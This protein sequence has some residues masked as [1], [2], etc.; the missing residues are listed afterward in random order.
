MPIEWRP[1]ARQ[2]HLHNEWVSY[3]MA[4]PDTAAWRTSTSVQLATCW[5]L[6][7]L[8]RLT[9][10]YPDILF[11]SCASGGGRFDPG[12]L[13]YAPQAWTSDDTDAVERLR[14]QYGTSM[15]YPLNTMGAHVSAVP[16]HQVGRVTDIDT[17]A[18]VAFFGN[19]GYELDPR[20]LAEEERVRV[21]EQVAWYKERRSLLHRGRFLRLVSPFDGDGNETAWRRSPMTG[22][23]RSW[24]GTASCRTPFRDPPG[25]GYAAWIRRHATG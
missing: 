19:C 20:R 16:N 3:L 21:R 25:C 7:P 10:R 23:T 8:P 1:E 9:S 13:A 2:L 11:E 14:V 18:A 5:V 4:V 22:V 12:M 6:R 15:V 24:A 17:R